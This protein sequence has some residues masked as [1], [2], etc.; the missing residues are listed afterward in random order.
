MTYKK[1]RSELKKPPGFW[2][3]VTADNGK[4]VY[5]WQEEE[6]P[7]IQDSELVVEAKEYMDLFKK[8]RLQHFKNHWLPLI[9]EKYDVAPH[10]SGYSILD[11]EFGRVD[12]YPTGGKLLIRNQGKWVPEGLVWIVK[13]LRI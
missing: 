12:F 10:T 3:L 5:I 7:Y 11:T 9:T 1:R 13:N 4:S 2:K 8:E 6:T